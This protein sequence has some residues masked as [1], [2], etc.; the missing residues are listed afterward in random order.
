MKPYDNST[1]VDSFEETKRGIK[2]PNL[3]LP[4]YE[5]ATTVYKRLKDASAKRVYTYTCIKQMFDGN[6]PFSEKDRKRLGI[7]TSSN[8][9]PK[10]SQAYRRA[11]LATFWNLN[12]DVKHLP[13]VEINLEGALAKDNKDWSRRVSSVWDEVLRADQ[14]FQAHR[15]T[16]LND[17]VDYGLGAIRWKSSDDWRPEWVDVWKWFVPNQTQNSP[18]NFSFT[19]FEHTMT[20]HELWDIYENATDKS[21]WQKTNLGQLLFL[22]SG[23]GQEWSR[24]GN[25]DSFSSNSM[26]WQ[27]QIKRGDLSLTKEF[28]RDI[29][30]VTVNAREFSGKISQYIIPKEYTLKITQKKSYEGFLFVAEG[31]YESFDEAFNIYT[32]TPGGHYVHDNKGLGHAIYSSDQ[33]IVR[34][35]NTFVDAAMREGTILIR[36]PASSSKSLESI[37]IVPGGMT[38]IGDVELQQ[39]VTGT[40][41]DSIIGAMNFL[42]GQLLQNNN[43]SGYGFG[44][45]PQLAGKT[46]GEVQILATTQGQT[47]KIVHEIYY[48]HED[49]TY[50]EMFRKM[51]KNKKDKATKYLIEQCKKEGV[52]ED[53][54]EEKEEGLYKLPKHIR[55]MASRS[56]GTGS[57]VADIVKSQQMMQSIMAFPPDGQKEILKDFTTSIQGYRQLD[58]YM[59]PEYY[60]D[61][62]TFA[63]IGAAVENKLAELG[64]IKNL[65]SDK[66][67]HVAHFYEHFNYG[68][69]IIELI[70][71]E[72]YPLQKGAEVLQSLGEHMSQ[73]FL[74]LQKDS[75]KANYADDARQKWA[76][77]SNQAA[78]YVNNAKQEAEAEANRAQAE[79]EAQAQALSKAALAREEMLM[80]SS[81][82]DDKLILDQTAKRKRDAM[83]QARKDEVAR[84]EQGRLDKG[85]D[86]RFVANKQRIENDVY[87]KGRETQTKIAADLM[88]MSSND[89]LNQAKKLADET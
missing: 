68:A 84:R 23:A 15:M 21:N 18:E 80:E 66:Q 74:M 49:R 36:T 51:L 58:K 78:F 86:L 12:N 89:R 35:Y 53:V 28:N 27:D 54:F 41:L 45:D 34:L 46:L 67:D 33:A 20:A 57:Q 13:N 56:A 48:S 39:V 1:E 63:E 31:M 61:E 37:K 70:G 87:W 11:V 77:F 81:R 7:E 88:K 42:Q 24:R 29:E 55:V 43:I 60:E 79:Q 22:Y 64:E 19:C 76:E 72:Q 3:S 17:V 10:N 62:R 25:V 5:A 38:N 47:Q 75:L 83:E 52:P 69:N 82:K 59:S 44:I 9:N 71:Q 30:L 2:A 26:Q 50:R 8:F 85:E 6:P 73:H 32:L 40:R 65:F 16:L 4:N 14:T